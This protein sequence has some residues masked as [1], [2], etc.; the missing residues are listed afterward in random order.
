MAKTT[1]GNDEAI[2]LF[3]EGARS[4]RD[5]WVAMTAFRHEAYKRCRNVVMQKLPALG[6]AIG[7]DSINE[8]DVKDHENESLDGIFLGVQVHSE[9]MSTPWTAMYFGLWWG[10]ENGQPWFGICTTYY[11][12]AQRAVRLLARLFPT[13]NQLVR[14]GAE[15]QLW[16]QL[17][18]EKMDSFDNTLAEMID[19]WVHLGKELGGFS[20]YIASNP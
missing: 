8:A 6:T 17:A 3:E 2:R 12:S 20:E 10:E 15:L 18:P 19:E 9:K 5:A 4:Y 13:N 16:R 1:A 11:L 7:D 14:G